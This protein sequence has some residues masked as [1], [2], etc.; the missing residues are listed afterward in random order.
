MAVNFCVT[1][2]RNVVRYLYISV[3]DLAVFVL[4]LCLYSNRS[5]YGLNQY[6]VMGLT[7]RP[8]IIAVDRTISASF[9]HGL[10]LL[11]STVS[12]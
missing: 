9:C 2:R 5:K 10:Q 3:A 1:E 4:S 11:V 8:L 7:G 6:T 12:F